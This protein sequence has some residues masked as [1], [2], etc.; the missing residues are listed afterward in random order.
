MIF[1][2][3]SSIV[4]LSFIY[5]FAQQWNNSIGFKFF[6]VFILVKVLCAMSLLFYVLDVL[7]CY[8]ATFF[9]SFEFQ[10]VI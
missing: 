8:F 7:H 5:S 6:F 3:P 9:F 2:L 1:R 10:L 4:V